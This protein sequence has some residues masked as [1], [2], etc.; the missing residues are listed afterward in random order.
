MLHH[1]RVTKRLVIIGLGDTGLLT[2]MY[3]G[4]AMDVVGV[5][6]HLDR[7]VGAIGQRFGWDQAVTRRSNVAPVDVAPDD[8]ID[9]LREI[10]TA[11]QAI[12][13]HARGLADS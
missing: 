10:N 1:E 2:A 12:W 8:I 11:D 6:D 13:T 3:V 5:L 7:F 4:D 9:R